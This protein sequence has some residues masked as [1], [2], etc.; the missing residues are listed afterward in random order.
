[1][2]N[3]ERVAEISTQEELLEMLKEAKSKETSL[4]SQLSQAFLADDVKS[5]SKLVHELTYLA[6]LKDQ[7]DEKSEHI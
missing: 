4:F 1:M 7:I 3:Q 6:R 5:A 2:E